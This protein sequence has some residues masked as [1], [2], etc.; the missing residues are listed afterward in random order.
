LITGQH[1]LL[2]S[3]A[4]F[5]SAGST[6][7]VSTAQPPS[8]RYK[9]LEAKINK[10]TSELEQQEHQFLTQAT[11]VNAWNKLLIDNSEKVPNSF[12]QFLVAFGQWNAVHG[13]LFFCLHFLYKESSF[14]NCIFAEPNYGD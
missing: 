11:Q 9:D 5:C 3:I 6:T 10:W 14:N 4:L 7:S 8:L 1:P 13:A 12:F 2:E